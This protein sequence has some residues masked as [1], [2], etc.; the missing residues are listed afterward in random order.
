MPFRPNALNLAVHK[1]N[2]T[3]SLPLHQVTGVEVRSG[4]VTKIIDIKTGAGA[5]SMRCYGAEK[6][7]EQIRRQHE[8][9]LKNPPPQVETPAPPGEK[10]QSKAVRL[11]ETKQL[12]DE[13]ILTEEE[14]QALKKKIIEGE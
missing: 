11:R 3:V 5:L 8:E 10:P 4:F 7:A 6:F 12:F 9:A 1:G 13:G 2:Y 14:F